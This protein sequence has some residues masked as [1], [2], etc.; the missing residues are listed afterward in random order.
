MKMKV[1]ICAVHSQVGRAL[2]NRPLETAWWKKPTLQ[3]FAK[4][5]VLF[6]GEALIWETALLTYK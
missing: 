4:W 3:S 6:L 1:R 2:E 5:G